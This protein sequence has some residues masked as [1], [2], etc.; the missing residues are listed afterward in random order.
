MYIKD[1]AAFAL[2]ALPLVHSSPIINVPESSSLSKSKRQ[3]RRSTKDQMWYYPE[4]EKS[5]TASGKDYNAQYVSGD[6]GRHDGVNSHIDWTLAKKA[7]PLSAT[8]PAGKFTVWDLAAEGDEKSNTTGIADLEGKDFRCYDW[9]SASFT[10]KRPDNSEKFVCHGKYYCVRQE[11][12]IRRTKITI[13]NDTVPVPMTMLSS[14][15]EEASGVK[16]PQ[17]LKNIQAGFR[18]L[19]TAVSGAWASSHPFPINGTKHNLYYNV[20]KSEQ[21][22]D[23]HYDPTRIR[24]IAD[25]LIKNV[26]SSLEQSQEK[27]PCVAGFGGSAPTCKYITYWPSEITVQVQIA[28]QYLQEWTDQDTIVIRV[29]TDETGKDSGCLKK[30]ANAKMMAGLISAVGG[31]TGGMAGAVASGLGGVLG[32]V[33]DGSCS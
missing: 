27:K 30:D 9:P 12:L 8:F 23:A 7:T 29:G 1:F 15:K 32:I 14:A 3:T 21:K 20:K 28:S 5:F 11:R 33:A 16:N 26:A 4:F 17:I 19:E 25:L 18:N 10:M 6:N 2:A 31:I 13:T 24:Q 22:D